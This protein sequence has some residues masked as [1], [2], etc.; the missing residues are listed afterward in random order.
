MDVFIE[1]IEP[2]PS[3]YVIGAGHV[4]HQLATLAAGVGFQVHVVDDREKFVN[5]D[6]FPDATSLHVDAIGEWLARAPL[7]PSASVVVVT[8]GHRHDFDALRML[9]MRELRYIGVIGSRAKIARLTD[10]L[11]E[12]GVSPEWL[13]RV[14]APIGL[15]I[16]AVTPEEIA[17]AILAELI[18]VRRGRIDHPET[19]GMSLQWTAPALRG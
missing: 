14:R 10:R 19:A 16:G 8:R 5:R 1:A 3:L 11:L 12:E 7:A 6:R 9:A 13:R 2:P 18:A 17:V 4:G 15:D